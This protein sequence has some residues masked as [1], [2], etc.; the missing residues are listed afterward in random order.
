MTEPN[1]APGQGGSPRGEPPLRPMRRPRP[2]SLSVVPGFAAGGVR[3]GDATTSSLAHH[4]GPAGPSSPLRDRGVAG[5]RGESSPPLRGRP[6]SALRGGAGNPPPRFGS[7]RGYQ[8]P[9]GASSGGAPPLRGRGMR[10]HGHGHAAR[11]SA[12]PLGGAAAP[13]PPAHSSSLQPLSSQ[14]VSPMAS[15]QPASSPPPLP[16]YHRASMRCSPL[17]PSANA[18][19]TTTATATTASASAAPEQTTPSALVPAATVTPVPLLDLRGGTLSSDEDSIPSPS[20]VSPSDGPAS[21]PVKPRRVSRPSPRRPGPALVQR[22]GRRSIECSPLS[23]P[24]RPPDGTQSPT[25]YSSNSSPRTAFYSVASVDASSSGEALS[26]MMPTSRDNSPTTSATVSA[27]P[28]GSSSSSSP[29]ASRIS[30]TSPASKLDFSRQFT[31]DRSSSAEARKRAATMAMS[32]TPSQF[33]GPRSHT[34]SSDGE[35]KGRK[36]AGSLDSGLHLLVRAFYAQKLEVV[37]QET[38]VKLRALRARLEASGHDASPGRDGE[39]LAHTPASSPAP[40]RRV[41]PPRPPR[42]RTSAPRAAFRPVST[43]MGGQ[44][45]AAVAGAEGGESECS[46][47]SSRV[48]SMR[49]ASPVAMPPAPSAPDSIVSSLIKWVDLLLETPPSNI[50][51]GQELR[52]ILASLLKLQNRPL[53]P[54]ERVL[55]T[56]LLIILSG[57][58]RMV[59]VLELEPVEI[60]SLITWAAHTPQPQQEDS[61]TTDPLLAFSRSAAQSSSAPAANVES[62]SVPPL[63]QPQ[64]RRAAAVDSPRMD[65]PRRRAFSPPPPSLIPPSSPSTATP[66]SPHAVAPSQSQKPATF[67]AAASSVSDVTASPSTVTNAARAVNHAPTLASPRQPAPSSMNPPP[68]AQF[69]VCRLCE[70][71][72]KVD[73]FAGHSQPCI[74]F[75]RN[76][77]Q[78]HFMGESIRK[79]TVDLLMKETRLQPVAASSQQRKHSQRRKEN[80]VA[81]LAQV[82]DLVSRIIGLE[83]D[84]PDCLRTGA[85]VFANFRSYRQA[86]RSLLSEVASTK[87]NIMD[88]LILKKLNLLKDQIRTRNHL[89]KDLYGLPPGLQEPILKGG[90]RTTFRFPSP[91]KNPKTGKAQLP[92]TKPKG[93]GGGPPKITDFDIIKPISRGSF[94]AVVLGRKRTTGDVYAI[95]ILKKKEMFRKNQEKYVQNERNILAMAHNPFVVKLYYSFQS[96]EYL[97]L[98]MEYLSGG[99][100]FSLLRVLGYFEEDQAR[101][102]IAETVLALEYLHKNGVVH[103]DLKPDNM[104]INNHGHIKLTDFGLSKMGLVEQSEHMDDRLSFKT[105]MNEMEHQSLGA[106]DSEQRHK[107]AVGTPDY[108]APEVFLGT[109]YGKTVDWWALGCIMYEFLVGITPFY[110]DTVNEIFENALSGVIDWPDDVEVSDEAKDLVHAMLQ[111][112]PEQRL[113]YRGAEELKQHHW[114]KGVDWQVL[115]TKEASFVPKVESED[116]TSYFDARNEIYDIDEL[117]KEML[118]DS[119]DLP[120]LQPGTEEYMSAES[121]EL[122]RLKRFS[123]VS[124][125]HLEALNRKLAEL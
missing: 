97:Y 123:F 36:R 30:P 67:A 42:P 27:C 111:V 56:R 110:A 105:F 124:V 12:S 74:K 65:S 48:L 8:Q 122:T 115:L 24:G 23:S 91:R 51:S 87:L 86:N 16:V 102:Y 121:A 6:L 64:P 70:N 33:G 38:D 15:S 32:T 101:Q 13:P 107:S 72:I 39:S 69:Q 40:I 81:N 75:T 45:A 7:G 17:L 80:V 11:G 34:P 57:L 85:E 90:A 61:L 116:D 41:P 92:R 63:S 9:P 114:F 47:N 106:P 98:V 43:Y 4:T 119:S 77:T 84:Q 58:S 20:S 78:L 76:E 53:D 44:A 120:N 117:E 37:K 59:T 46:S 60:N 19:V 5:L 29:T 93:G 55:L 66:T 108:I 3:G 21:S 18:T 103:R 113:G 88:G 68:S 125:E 99:D 118:A 95:K 71:K 35:R 112:D 96:P 14:H 83:L 50:A 2:N 73:R 89:M 62:V 82:Q 94:G 25:S 49:P 26:Q 22:E 54:H 52:T 100:C 104:L 109:G 1:G 31:P 79:L 28:G 10:G